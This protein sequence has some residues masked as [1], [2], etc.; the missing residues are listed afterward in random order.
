MIWNHTIPQLSP[1]RDRITS[2]CRIDETEC[3]EKL[4]QEAVFPSAVLEKIQAIGASL[5]HQT[6]E[7]FNKQ[8]GAASFLREYDLSSEEGIALMC[9]AEALLRIP[10]THTMDQLI[11]DKLST[12]DW[13]HSHSAHS[14]FAHAAAWSLMLTGRI[15]APAIHYQKTLSASLKC[16]LSQTGETLLR[17]AILQ[18]VKKISGQFVMGATIEEALQRAKPMESQGYRYSYDMLGEAARTQQDADRYFTAY[19]NAIA[20]LGKTVQGP[21]PIQ[22]PGISVKLSALHPRYEFA[23]RE[24]ILKEL[25]PR[26]LTL[27]RAA[28]THRIGLTVDAEEADRLELSMDLIEAV[29]GDPALG[30][31]EGFGLALQSYQKRA[32]YVIDWLAELA[33]QQKRRLVVRLVKG[34]YWDTE[35]KI[36]QCLGL[37]GYPVFTRKHS[38]DVSFIACAKK[39]LAHPDCFYPQFGTHNAYSIAAILALVQPG[40]DF[41]FQCLYGIGGPLYGSIVKKTPCRIYAPV[42]NDK[43]LPGYLVRRL[44]E[45]GANSS[46]LNQTADPQVPVETLM[47]DPVA[48]VKSL[49]HKPHPHIPLPENIYGTERRNSQGL[50]LSSHHTLLS[51]KK[52]ME[53]AEKQSWTADP[54]HTQH[55]GKPVK[56]PANHQHIV[57]YVHEAAIEDLDTALTIAAKAAST[58]ANTSV[59]ERTNCLERAAD[60]L[61]TH[62]AALLTL[63]CREG[64]KTIAD[65]A[66]EVREAID[67][68]RYY[69]MRAR[70]DLQPQLLQGPT[71]E[72]NSLA[73]HPR[74]ITACISPWNFPLAIF[75]G[76]ITAALV[77]GNPVIAK[78]AEQTPLI[79]QEAV[80]LLHAAGIPKNVLHLL[81]GEGS[82]IGEKLVA[83]LRVAAVMF[84]GSVDTARQIQQVLAHRSG[85]IIPFIAETGGQNAM[86]VD[87]SALLE[88]V[89]A[90]V[91]HSAFNSAGQRCSALRVLFIQEDISDAL[92]T[93]LKGAAAELTAGDPALLATDIGPVIDQ[94]AMDILKLHFEKMKKEARLVYS[95]PLQ[96]ETEKGYFFTPCIFEINSLN[97]LPGE[98]F[99]PIL[100]VIR[101]PAKQ[102][103]QVLDDIIHTGYGLTA[104]IHSR[105]NSVVEY[106]AHRLPVGNLYVNRNMIGAVV[107]VQPFGGEG[108]SGTGPKAGGPYYLPKLCVERSISINTSAMGGNT[109]LINASE[110]H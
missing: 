72:S 90:D 79:A 52:S 27:A 65:G 24:R 99:G 33:R 37:E 28:K 8:G 110:E 19:S 73:L 58:W 9:L 26:L 93:L 102:L 63:L 100:H 17:P 13:L 67:F 101:Y 96:Q 62:R 30:E 39:L 61:E 98:V 87:S 2:A 41:E 57:G 53:Q 23:Q 22:G 95:L 68:C 71:G 89:T 56:S 88:Q 55:P 18:G 92:L 7:Q 11:A 10:D 103:D 70:Y 21:N 38:T 51:L 44:L 66:A 6:R 86:I 31:W 64:G 59:T 45:N 106:M 109:T 36:S 5:I 16:L 75:I 104:G 85:P 40:Q 29:Y 4:L 82:T 80:R 14:L 76:Q 46:F 47:Q 43:D 54:G 60:L 81:P 49:S 78:P 77:C 35:I 50:D 83:D 48:R 32:F 105:I 91:I 12:L 97:Q 108:L 74:G 1:L 34:A 20:A 15:F 69:A 84:T 107:G 3:L 94:A 42:G 25:L